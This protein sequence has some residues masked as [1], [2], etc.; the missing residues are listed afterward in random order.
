MC[1][2]SPISKILKK[3]WYTTF[4]TSSILWLKLYVLKKAVDNTGEMGRE[5]EWELYC[6]NGCY[7]CAEHVLKNTQEVLNKH[8]LIIAL[9]MKSY[10]PTL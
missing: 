8:V 5:N 4:C 9:G 10:K 6:T 3:F 7:F 1:S 2:P